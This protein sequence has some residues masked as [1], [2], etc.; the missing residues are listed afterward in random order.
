MDPAMPE[1]R[2]FGQP[3]ATPPEAAPGAPARPS[4]TAL[5][6][7]VPRSTLIA[8]VAAAAMT[9]GGLALFLATP[10]GGDVTIVDG[11][12]GA[13]MAAGV[14]QDPTDP[15]AAGGAGAVPAGELVIDVAGAVARPG[16]VRVPA[17]S[18]VGDAIAAAGGYAVTAD[19]A[20][21]GSTLN[22]AAPVA[23]GDKVLVPVLTAA[24]PGAAA[25]A[26]GAPAGEG[27]GPMGGKVDLNRADQ[28]GLEALPGIGPVT[29]GRIIEARGQAPFRSVDE[30]RSRGL[31]GESTFAKL[32]DL[33]TAGS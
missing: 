15:G 13:V 10:G 21:A 29:A 32:R 25:D 9:V 5:L 33:V 11:A 8:L 18:R 12:G 22:L 7:R 24:D 23:D 14:A 28:A 26:G 19:L 16:L 27:G 3:A 1:W 17:G 31:V 6:A 4:P 20:A 30:L 2:A